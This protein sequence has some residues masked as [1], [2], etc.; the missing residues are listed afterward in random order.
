METRTEKS[1]VS[2]PPYILWLYLILSFFIRRDS[3]LVKT[4][5]IRNQNREL[6]EAALDSIITYKGQM[7]KQTDL[8]LELSDA[9]L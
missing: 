9:D 6:L 5:D 1:G 3:V 4:T 8:L 2:A 7:M